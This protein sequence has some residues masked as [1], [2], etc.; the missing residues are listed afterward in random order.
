[1][2]TARSATATTRPWPTGTPQSARSA[3]WTVRMRSTAGRS[4]A[5]SSVPTA[6]TA[7]PH[8]PPA[9]TWSDGSTEGGLLCRNPLG[10]PDCPRRRHMA[11]EPLMDPEKLRAYLA[12]TLGEEHPLSF[13]GQ[14]ASGSSNLTYFFNWGDAEWV[15]RR[16]PPGPLPPGA[17]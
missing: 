8:P 14:T 16:P 7:P 6:S 17:H 4:G 15:I 10:T 3:L 9:A 1:S 11:E 12:R 13:T 2:S 5:T